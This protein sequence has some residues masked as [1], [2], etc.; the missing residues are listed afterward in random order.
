MKFVSLGSH[1]GKIGSCIAIHQSNYQVTVSLSACR[2]SKLVLGLTIL[3]A[4]FL[5]IIPAKSFIDESPKVPKVIGAIIWTCVNSY[6]PC[7][8]HKQ[9]TSVLR[10]DIRMLEL[11][12]LLLR[13]DSRFKIPSRW[14]TCP[15]ILEAPRGNGEVVSEERIVFD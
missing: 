5:T 6:K 2:I 4:V 14:S 15:K 3:S 7:L 8:S 10:L 9:Q 13:P 1:S 12:P 11:V